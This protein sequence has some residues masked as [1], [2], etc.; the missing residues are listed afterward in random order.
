MLHMSYAEKSNSI[1]YHAVQELVIMLT[2]ECT[3]DLPH[4]AGGTECGHQ[5]KQPYK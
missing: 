5:W 4:V 3:D 1:C 2:H